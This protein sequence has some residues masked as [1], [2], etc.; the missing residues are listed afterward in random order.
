MNVLSIWPTTVEGWVGFAVLV[1][2]LI[3]AIVKLVPTWI[4]AHKLTIE[5]IRQK[6]I[7]KLKKVASAAMSG[8]QASLKTGAEKK[9]IVMSSIE[10][11]SKQM[12]IEV[13]QAAWSELSKY[14]DDMKDYFNKMKESNERKE[15]E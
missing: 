11:A 8:A 12:G 5:A 4:Q 13:D 1:I 6:N 7:E 9:E 2:G 10:A 14:I 15:E 3:S